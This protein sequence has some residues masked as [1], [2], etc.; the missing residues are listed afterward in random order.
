MLHA[1]SDWDNA[2]ANASNIPGGADYPARWTAR[3]DAFRAGLLAERRARLDLGHGDHPRDRFDLF[4]PVGE[5]RGLVV[6]I[7]GGYWMRFDKSSCS[8][9]AAGPLARGLAVAMPS[10]PLCP[11]VRIAAIAGHVARAIEVAAQAVPG[12]IMLSGHSAGGHLASRLMTMGSPLADAVRARVARVVSISGVHDLRPLMRT[13]MNDT[14]RLDAAEAA[15]ESP[16][17]L[18]P[19]PGLE[20]IAWAG[21]TERAEFVRQNG[22]IASLWLGLGART[23]AVLEPDRH[24]FDVID[25]LADPAHPLTAA[26]AGTI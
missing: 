11:D 8:H 16:A 26:I 9:L 18:T 1:I 7:H 22:L 24:H 12:P 20:L 6:F 21:A 17:L 4:L 25:G 3:A 15:A 5:P 2:Y 13:A 23:E 14:L 10:Y 19:V